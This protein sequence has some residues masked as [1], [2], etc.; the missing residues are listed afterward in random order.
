MSYLIL[1]FIWWQLLSITV[2]SSGYH[3]YFAH[4]AFKTYA[5]YEYWVLFLGTLTASGPLL[6]WVGVHRQ[7]HNH[8]D[9]EDDP[10]SPRHQGFV[11]VLTSTFKVKAIR[12][13]TIKDLLRNERVMWFYRNHMII[14]CGTALACFV[15][16]S[17]PMFLV[18]FVSPIIY[19][20]I[21]FGAINAFAHKN[22]KILNIHWLNIL[23]AGEGYHKNHHEDPRAW[24]LGAYDPSAVFIRL[25]KK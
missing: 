18:I 12:H 2:V 22:G 8:T 4:R 19:S 7:H 14:R 6:G 25:I 11:P 9:T 20:Y 24:K 5:L 3:R 1:S 21:G 10:H 23:S 15:L 13:R 16:L 17:F